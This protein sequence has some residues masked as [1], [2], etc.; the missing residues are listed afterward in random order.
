MAGIYIHIPFCKTRCIYCGFYSTT[1][2][3][4]QDK[5]VDAVIKEFRLRRDYLTEPVETMYL[6]GG[7]PS[8]LS[9][10]NLRK[11][12]SV[13]SGKTNDDSIPYNIKEITV[14]CNPD[15]VSVELAK[16][17]SALGVN[18]VSMGVQSFSDQRLHFLH[19]RHSAEQARNA[20]K[21]LRNSGINNISIDLMFGFPGETLEDWDFDINEAI[22]LGV[23]HISAYSLM[24]EEKTPLFNMLQKGQIKEID[25]ELSR[26]MYYHLIDRLTDAG[27]EHYEISNFAKQG[28]R[29]RHNS[30]YWNE[31][32]YLGLGAGAHSYNRT[33]RQWNISDVKSYI[34]NLENG[35]VPFENEQLDDITV[36]NDRVTTSLRTKEGIEIRDDRF[37][38]HLLRNARPLIERGLLAENNNHLHL[39]RSGLYVSDDV[40]AELIFID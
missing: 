6:G 3:E 12:I 13:I 31:T 25:E 14:E 5:Y 27:Y 7:T 20:V 8:Q 18:R 38:D 1:L 28:Y 21:I 11:L 33:S 2:H 23:E 26:Q 17:L 22:S 35:I 9:I 34:N 15:D 19:R 40:M 10:E 39:T 29:S 4:L 32:P 37:K 24:Y 16:E 30:S 36:Y